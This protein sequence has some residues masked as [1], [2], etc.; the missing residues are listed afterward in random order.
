MTVTNLPR[1]GDALL[2][3]LIMLVERALN[4]LEAAPAA[5][6]VLVSNVTIGALDTRVY[7]GLG[8]KITGYILVR[9]PSGLNVSDGVAAETLDPAHYVS[10]RLSGVFVPTVV[11]LLVF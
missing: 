1:I 7:H 4:A 9:S 3:R 2:Q 8:Q 10:L 11:S 5:T 6:A